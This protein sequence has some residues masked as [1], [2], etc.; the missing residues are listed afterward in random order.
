MFSFPPALFIGSRFNSA[1]AKKFSSRTV[2][3]QEKKSLLASH[4]V[5]VQATLGIEP[6]GN[7]YSPAIPYR[8]LYEMQRPYGW[9]DDGWECVFNHHMLNRTGEW[10]HPV[11]KFIQKVQSSCVGVC[12]EIFLPVWWSGVETAFAGFFFSNIARVTHHAIVRQV[13]KFDNPPS[14]YRTST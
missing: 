3:V 1:S 2:Q 11:S 9:D 8:S 12:M 13:M 7:D 10:I 14:S 4:W 6:S 5:L